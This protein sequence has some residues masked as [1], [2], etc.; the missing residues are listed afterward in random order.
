MPS[1]SSIDMTFETSG[2]VSVPQ[3][4]TCFGRKRTLIRPHDDSGTG[5]W[6]NAIF[7][8]GV[9]VSGIVALVINEGLMKI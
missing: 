8:I 4:E 9:T 5:V 7:L 1:V 3:K 6:V 2:M